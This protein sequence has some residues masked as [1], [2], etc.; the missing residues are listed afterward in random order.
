MRVLLV[1]LFCLG[2]CGCA[3]IVKGRYQY[4]DFDTDPTGAKLVVKYLNSETQ[5]FT[6]PAQMKLATGKEPYSVEISKEGYKSLSIRM[7]SRLSCW[8]YANIA[9]GLFA[10]GTMPI[11]L[12]SGAAYTFRKTDYRLTLESINTK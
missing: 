7:E 3:S 6:T 12:M 11:D 1:L 5:T 9:G 2:L 10:L 8:W 4:V